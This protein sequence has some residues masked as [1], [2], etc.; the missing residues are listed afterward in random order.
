M[1]AAAA[2]GKCSKPRVCRGKPQVRSLCGPA[3]GHP[4]RLAT[5]LPTAPEPVDAKLGWRPGPCTHL[6]TLAGP[7]GLS[8]AQHPYL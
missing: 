7:L 5:L 4:S 3:D 1:K 8:D 6:V 2:A